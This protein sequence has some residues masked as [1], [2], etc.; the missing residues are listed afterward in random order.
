VISAVVVTSEEAAETLEVVEI[1]A[2]AVTSAGAVATSERC[3]L[4]LA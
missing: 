4:L 1:L 2:V 3:L